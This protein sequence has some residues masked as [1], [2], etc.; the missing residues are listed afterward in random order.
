M[1][2]KFKEYHYEIMASLETDEDVTRE[3]VFF[4]EHQCK[5][6]EFVDH[7]VDPLAKPHLSV[8]TPSSTNDRLVD[9]QLD[10]FGDSV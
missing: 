7:L 1:C 4:D 10:L 8:P 9:I 6:M 2:S 3:Q 5:T